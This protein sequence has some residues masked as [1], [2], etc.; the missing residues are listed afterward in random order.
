MGKT[1]KTQLDK[2][3]AAA[4]AL[5]RKQFGDEAMLTFEE[6]TAI[7]KIETISTGSLNLDVALGVGGLTMG[8]INTIY[9]E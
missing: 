5:I 2:D 7:K 8:R 9:G 1:E 4:L 6:T 3:A